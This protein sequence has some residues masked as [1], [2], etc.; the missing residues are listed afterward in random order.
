MFLKYLTEEI[1]TRKSND[2]V[3]DGWMIFAPRLNI[4]FS[5]NDIIRDEEKRKPNF[6]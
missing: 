3:S 4:Y 1:R 2:A 5:T 6:E